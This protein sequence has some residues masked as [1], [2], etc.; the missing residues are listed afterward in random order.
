[1][2]VAAFLAL[3]VGAYVVI[4]ST[5]TKQTISSQKELIDTLRTKGEVQQEEIKGLKEKQE[6]Q[7]LASTQAIA[8]LRGQVNTLRDIPL[9]EIAGDI[10]TI[11]ETQH[12]IINHLGLTATNNEAR[13]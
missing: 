6:S 3:L 2:K 8:E 13:S 11:R 5:S 12:E 1:M 10:A 9:K 7:H 4:R